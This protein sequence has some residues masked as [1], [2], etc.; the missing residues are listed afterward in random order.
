MIQKCW[1]RGLALLFVLVLSFCGCQSNVAP[2]NQTT[3]PDAT[4]TTPSP[5]TTQED[6]PMPTPNSLMWEYTTDADGVVVRD[7]TINTAKGGDPLTI[8]QITDLHFNYCNQQDLDEADPVILSTLEKR[9]W[10]KDGK[11]V[12]NTLRCLAYAENAEQLVVTGDI[13]DYLSHGTIELTKKHLFDPYPEL[14]ACLG[15]HEPV[16]QMQGTVADTTSFESRMERLQAIWPHDI[17]YASKVL[18]ER[19]MLIQLDNGSTGEFWESQIEPFQ[20]DLALAREKGYTVLLF[21]HIPL[22][23]GNVADYNNVALMVGDKNNSSWNFYTKGIGN[24][25][26]GASKTIYDLIVNNAD[27]IAGAF[28]GH[29]HSDFYTEIKAKTADGADAII[30]QYVLIGV[31]YG[32][33]HVLRI[34]VK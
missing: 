9:T 13:L 14:L 8:L 4:T 31:P 19:V 24:L 27:I 2:P 5:N 23:T 6:D 26:T 18:D 12:A 10:L 1:K 25:S 7:L 3:A 17:Y 22:S 29:K 20:K 11:S 30:P 15:N 33:G 28:C 21:Y 16:R 32:K 34:T